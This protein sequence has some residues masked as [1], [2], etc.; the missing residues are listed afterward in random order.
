MKNAK[1][2]MPWKIHTPKLLE[3]VLINPGMD[4]FRI[5]LQI[6]A[7]LLGEI[8]ERAI[9]LDDSRLNALM[10]RLTLYSCADPIQEDYDPERCE[11]VI[12]EA[13]AI[14]AAEKE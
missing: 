4:I 12:E 13:A 1:A 10:I 6:L 5:P 8:A 3:E 7:N 9:V 2:I 11:K 14:A